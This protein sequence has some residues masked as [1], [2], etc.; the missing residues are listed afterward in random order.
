MVSHSSVELETS[1]ATVFSDSRPE[2]GIEVGLT[3]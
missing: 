1:A 3:W 2:L